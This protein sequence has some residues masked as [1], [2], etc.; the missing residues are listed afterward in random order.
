MLTPRRPPSREFGLQFVF[1]AFI[2]LIAPPPTLTCRY[3]VESDPLLRAFDAEAGGAEGE[4]ADEQIDDEIAIAG[5]SARQV[6]R[7]TT[8]PITGKPLLELDDPVEDGMAFVYERWAIAE[9]LDK[10][11]G[12]GMPCPVAGTTHTVCMADLKPARAVL[13]AKKKGRGQRPAPEDDADV[14]ELD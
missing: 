11:R 5:E 1:L 7:N 6:V 10:R 12:G 14:V 9:M 4:A 8:C 2:S 13:A 3:T